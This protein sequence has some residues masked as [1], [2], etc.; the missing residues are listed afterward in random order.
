MHNKVLG[1]GG[2]RHNTGLQGELIRLGARFVIAGTDT[3]YVLAG[4]R[5][6]TAALRA[7]KID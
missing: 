4:A 3:N 6:D 5:Q 1:V 2:I 7:I